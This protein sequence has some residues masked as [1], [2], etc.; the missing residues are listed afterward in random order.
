[1]S[2][3]AAATEPAEG[4]P[5]KSS[6]VPQEPKATASMSEKE[7]QLLKYTP[8]GE[9]GWDRIK[10]MW[11]DFRKES[12]FSGDFEMIQTTFVYGLIGGSVVGSTLG[13][14]KSMSD[15]VRRFN[16]HQWEGQFMAGR[17]LRDYI[18]LQMIRNGF[19]LGWRCAVFS[20]MFTT[21][22]VHSFAYRNY[23]STID[24]G[25]SGALV[26]GLWKLKLGLRAAFVAG[27]VGGLLGVSASGMVKLGL[28]LNDT[29]IPELRHW[30]NGYHER[31][32]FQ[33]IER[34]RMIAKDET[35]SQQCRGHDKMLEMK[36]VKPL[37]TE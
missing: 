12:Y 9:T 33:E 24:F 19:K 16:E 27:L 14:R 11:T 7:R 1:M 3:V 13:M 36:G 30:T 18:V 10:Q 25:A 15:F 23:C 31:R 26:A 21:L 22:M 6:I 32:V 37:L 28:W 34:N 4:S 17:K 8:E 20:G 2:T 5:E 29:T 35:E